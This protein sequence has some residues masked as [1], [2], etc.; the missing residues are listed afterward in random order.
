MQ[1]YVDS[2]GRN[3]G[4]TRAM[5]SRPQVTDRDRVAAKKGQPDEGV[6]KGF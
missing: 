1:T 2:G 4:V 5:K 6:K 3:S